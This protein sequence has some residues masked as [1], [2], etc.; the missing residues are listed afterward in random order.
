MNVTCSTGTTIVNV[1]SLDAVSTYQFAIFAKNDI[2]TGP[3]TDAG[4]YLTKTTYGTPS[5]PAR[6]TLV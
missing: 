3:T 5:T 4:S 6:P 2:G 1:A